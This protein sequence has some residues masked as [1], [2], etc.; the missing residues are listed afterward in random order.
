MG[1][2]VHCENTL[3]E[4]LADFTTIR[5]LSADGGS[6]VVQCVPFAALRCFCIFGVWKRIRAV[7]CGR[8]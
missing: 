3:G 6:L 5:A 4:K 8:Q 2:C 1:K 7:F